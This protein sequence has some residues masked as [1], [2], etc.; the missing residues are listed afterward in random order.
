MRYLQVL[1][2]LDEHEGGLQHFA[3]SYSMYGVHP[4]RDAKEFEY[5]KCLEWL[6][7]VQSVHLI[8]DF[9]GWD[10]TAHPMTAL[11]FGRWEL[12]LP[13]D[14][15]K[16]GNRLK[17]AI[18]TQDGR[19]IERLSPWSTMAI[20]HPETHLYEA[21]YYPVEALALRPSVIRPPIPTDLFIYEAHIGIASERP[22]IATFN[23]F[24]RDMLPY[25]KDL[26]YNCIQLMAIQE[27]AYYASFGYQVTSFFGV[28]SRFGR[29]EDLAALVDAAHELGLVVILDLVHSHASKNSLD[30][31]NMLNGREDCYFHSGPRG[32]HPMWDSR[33]FDYGHTETLRLLLSNVHFWIQTYKVDGFRLDGIT[34]MLYWHRGVNR[35]FT[36]SYTDYLGDTANTD[37]D[38]AIYLML[39]NT[40]CDTEGAKLRIAEDVSGMP[41]LCRPIAEGGYGFQYRLALAVPDIY[42][43]FLKTILEDLDWPMDELVAT[44]VNRRYAEPCI[45]YTECHDQV[46]R[47]SFYAFRIWMALLSECL[48][49]LLDSFVLIG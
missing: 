30:G 39:A 8:G 24:T 34:S 20:P 22:G 7:N 33:C 5:I 13:S 25:I 3:S 45:A 42:I 36:G 11:P 37:L 32:M 12:I 17:L 23:E 26:G 28:S 6:P 16:K 31:L 43:R 19:H 35:S 27:H 40:L 48:L 49:Q 9:N 44:L 2:W 38:A 10:R 4:F 29:P 14:A 41:T 46:R 21:V 47:A 1:A 15:I 18:K